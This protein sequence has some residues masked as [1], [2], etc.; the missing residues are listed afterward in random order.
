M[1]AMSVLPL[2]PSAVRR[3]AGAAHGLSGLRISPVLLALGRDFSPSTAWWGVARARFMVGTLVLALQG[4]PVAWLPPDAPSPVARG[5]ASRPR[6]LTP[7]AGASGALSRPGE[8]DPPVVARRRAPPSETLALD[9]G[10]LGDDAP[11]SLGI[12]PLGRLFLAP[13]LVF[14]GIDGAEH[15]FPWPFPYLV[16]PQRL[17]RL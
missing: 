12:P 5:S 7:G 11:P 17:T 9:D 3:L 13:P 2:P 16:R 4:V 1:E 10:T 8:N 14:M 6:A 15:A